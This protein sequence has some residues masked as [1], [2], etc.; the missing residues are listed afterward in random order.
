M[1][2][3][4]DPGPVDQQRLRKRLHAAVPLGG[5]TVAQYQRIVDFPWTG[6]GLDHAP[7][8]VVRLFIHRNADDRETSAPPFILKVH[9][10]RHFP[11]TWSAPG[12]PKIDQH[13]LAFEAGQGSGDAVDVGQVEIRCRTSDCRNLSLHDGRGDP[14]DH[15]RFCPPRKRKSRDHRQCSSC[16]PFA[17]NAHS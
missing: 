4:H 14:V 12:G 5:Q 9:K 8:I 11:G 7:N 17:T 10:P 13:H 15:V 16:S 3:P 2:L 6:P 1:D